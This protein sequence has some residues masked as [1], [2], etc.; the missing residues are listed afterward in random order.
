M[1]MSAYEAR[2]VKF[3]ESRNGFD[4]DEVNAF[5]DAEADG[6]QRWEHGPTRGLAR[7]SSAVVRA[8]GPPRRSPWRWPR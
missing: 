5:R 3:S 7:R 4:Q 2:T 8:D 1:P 6:L